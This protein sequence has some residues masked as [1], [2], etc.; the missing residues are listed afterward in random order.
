MSQNKK[1]YFQGG[2][3]VNEPTPGK[4]KYVSDTAIVVQP[5]FEEPFYRN[6]DL[7]DVEGVSGPAKYGPGSGWHHMHEFKSIKDFLNWR[8]QRLHDKYVA[9]DFWIEDTEANRKQRVEKM[10]VRAELFGRMI[11]SAQRNYD[12][13]QGLY[14]NMDKYKSVEDFREG[15]KNSI[16][17]DIDNQI[18]SSPII[19]EMDTYPASAQLG[20]YLDKYLPLDDF[21]GKSPD[22]LDFGRDYTEDMDPYGDIDYEDLEKLMLKYLPKEADIYGLPDGIWPPED[23]DA[24]ATV[25]NI[26]P[27]AGETDSGN[28]LYEDKWNI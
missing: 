18:H 20:G 22:E 5:R 14:E 6:Y 19:G 3:G 12:L 9:D 15:D 23:K 24:D 8:R 11:K 13:G 21:E 28:T 27:E 26:N 10:K 4:K 2:G 25:N 1:A 16:D 17:F 7:Y